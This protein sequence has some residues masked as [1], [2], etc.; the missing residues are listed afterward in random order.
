MSLLLPIAYG[1]CR[2]LKNK[3]P[4]TE[5]GFAIR[6]AKTVERIQK[7]RANEIPDQAAARNSTIVAYMQT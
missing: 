2:L 3:T 1:S 4:P 5:E 7:S 6:R